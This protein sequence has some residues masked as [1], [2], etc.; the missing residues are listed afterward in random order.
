MDLTKN[1]KTYAPSLNTISSYVEK[2]VAGIQYNEFGF[3]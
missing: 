2:T 3:Y 1:H